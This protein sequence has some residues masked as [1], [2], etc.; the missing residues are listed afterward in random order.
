[1]S[2]T[3]CARLASCW[4]FSPDDT[5]VNV[6]PPFHIH[7]LSI[8]SH[9]ALLSGSHIVLEDAFHPVESLRVVD[10]ATVFMAV[11]TIYYKFLEQAEFRA[12]AKKWSHV[13]LFTC[14]SAR[15]A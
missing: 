4:R 5:L 14:G 15:S 2:L 1:M 8:A 12:A 9:L 13:R 7:G 11:P 10:K 6:L 3:L